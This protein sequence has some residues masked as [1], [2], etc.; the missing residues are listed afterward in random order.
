RNHPVLTLLLSV[1]PLLLPAL[2]GIWPARS[3]NRRAWTIG[4]SGLLI[5]L[6]ALYF[7]RLSDAS[8]IGFRAGQIIL[9]SLPLL[10]APVLARLTLRSAT[11]LAAL[12]F[13]IGFPTTAIDTWNAQDIG[14]RRPGPGF[15]WT[16]PIAPE[17]Q[18]AFA[19]IQANTPPT[20]V[21][22]MEPVVRGRDEWTLIPSFAARRM[23][24]GLPISLLPLPE[25]QERSER[26]KAIFSTPR[27]AEAADSAR[28]LR[29]DYLYVDET[30][31]AAYPEGTRKF[32]ADSALFERVY[33]NPSV[34]IY[35]VR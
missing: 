16:I 1:G 32:D 14:N 23:A 5:G 25:Y 31:V 30:D 33:A 8:W 21:V 9:V 20:A 18:Q 2:C 3:H 28:R 15:R 26:V 19:W 34:R 17:Q 4:S 22:Q 35:R 10:L 7:V 12:V 24:A 27:P 13:V 6:L 11:A 29:I